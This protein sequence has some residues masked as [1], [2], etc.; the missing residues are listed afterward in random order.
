MG[1]YV[2]WQPERGNVMNYRFRTDLSKTAVYNAVSDLASTVQ[3]P[4]IRKCEFKKY[5]GTY[6]LR[7]YSGDD[8]CKVTFS[9][10]Y[11]SVYLRVEQYDFD[12]D[13]YDQVGFIRVPFDYLLQNGCL[14]EV[15]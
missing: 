11:G 5:S 14:R 10:G 3:L 15:A 12:L 7:F 2:G 1:Y 13:H 4:S 8:F 6:W 9:S